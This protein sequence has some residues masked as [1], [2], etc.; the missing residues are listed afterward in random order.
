MTALILS[1]IFSQVSWADAPT[2]VV[3]Y[4]Y[5]E[6]L[7]A[8]LDGG[9][10][11]PPALDS[12]PLALSQSG[13]RVRGQSVVDDPVEAASCLPNDDGDIPLNCSAAFKAQWNANYK[14]G[15]LAQ[16]YRPNDIRGFLKGTAIPETC[17]LEVVDLPR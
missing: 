14:C 6:C 2:S 13:F 4:A 1:L 3:V 16:Q 7:V 8:D 12:S 17:Q 15:Q 10:L 5:C 9:E 11:I